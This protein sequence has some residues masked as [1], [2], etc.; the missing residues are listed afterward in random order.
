V[1]EAAAK[2]EKSLEQIKAMKKTK[3]VTRRKCSD[4]CKPR[5]FC[6]NYQESNDC[7]V[8]ACFRVCCEKK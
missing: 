2:L 7:F 3:E 5:E 4:I 1:K 8:C 6:Q